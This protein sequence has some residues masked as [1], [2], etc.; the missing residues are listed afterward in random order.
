M[1]LAKKSENNR[2]YFVFFGMLAIG[3]AIFT[4]MSIIQFKEGEHWRSKA[5]SLTIKDEIIPANRGNIYSADGS[6]LATSIPKY[7]VYFDPM[8]PSTE[9]FEK[10][11]RPFSDSLAKF[12]PKQTAGQY[13]AYF[14]KARSNKKRYI[15]I[16]TK[17]SYTQYMKLKS[18]PLFN[19]GKYKGGMIVNQVNVREYP[20]GMIANRTIGYERVNDDKTITRKGIEAAF[21]DYLTGKEGRRKVQKMSKNLWKP[22]HDEN[23]IDPQDGYDIT[24]TIDVYIQDIA[25]HALLSSLEYYEADHGTVVVMETSTGEIKAISNLGKIG[26]GSYTETVNYAVLERHDPGST[27]KLASYLA[28]LD[29]GKADTATIYDTHNGVVTFFNRRVT[30]SNRRG[31]GKIS[32]ARGFEVS[33]NTVAT[34]AV[35]QAY[36]DNP[37]AFTDKMKEFGFNQTLG[38][39]LKGEPA[40]YIPVPG[41]RNWSKIALPWMAYGYGIL[42]TPLQTLTLY[43]A[44]ANNGEM[45]KPHFVK[46]IRDVNNTLQTFEKE[47]INPQIVKPEVIKKM[48]AVMK[49]VVIRGSGKRLY[50]PDFSMAGKTGTAQMN[51]GKAKGGMYYASSFVGYFPADNPKYSCIVVIHRPTK[52]SYYGGDVA[53]PVFKRIAQK[54][55]TDVPSLNEIKD[56]ESPLPK[57]VKSY[58]N[59]YA[60][61]KQSGNVMPDV[62]G[63][64]AMDAVA[65]LEN[66][67]LKVQ[68]AGTGKVIRQSIKNGEKVEKNKIIILELS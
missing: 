42:V 6:L 3:I 36:K 28:L 24:T 40:S 20:M 12:I 56:I 58:K 64:P 33:S 61:V 63:L 67:G 52:H 15:H 41:D 22:I 9:N 45:V 8:S 25:H 21:T 38:L 50:S 26:N 51:Y 47:V 46:E 57:A 34:Q 44:V 18:F 68:T 53:G 30:D 16:A 4:K 19:L 48:Q 5:D 55:F 60:N 54:I 32:L 7:T 31:Y 23:E 27:F 59:Y 39:D 2:I 13:E 10:Y 1:G 29:D 49:N 17:L 11:I 37:K 35:Y 43:N 14:R 65:I 62:L 66:L